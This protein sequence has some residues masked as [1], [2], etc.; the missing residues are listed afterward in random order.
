MKWYKRFPGDY[1]AKTGH[2]SLVERGAYDALLDHYYATEEALPVELLR[3]CRIAGAAEPDEA[4]AVKRVAAQFFPING[5]GTRHNKR[6]DEEIA[7]AKAK[8]KASAKGGSQRANGMSEDE[9]RAAAKKAA[10]A[11]WNA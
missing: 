9:R 5:D 2:L 10:D 8:A 6:A 11:R 7:K 4:A 1:A 3:L